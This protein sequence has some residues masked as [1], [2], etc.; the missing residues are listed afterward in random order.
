VAAADRRRVAR[1]TFET[2]TRSGL[3]REEI[4]CY[5]CQ[6]RLDADARAL[7]GA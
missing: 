2:D 1:R 3:S 5:A 4:G 7:T 6:I